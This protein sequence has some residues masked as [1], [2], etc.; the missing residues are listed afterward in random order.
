MMNH[1]PIVIESFAC[2]DS[3]SHQGEPVLER[4]EGKNLRNL[5]NGPIV[6][7][8]EAKNLRNLGKGMKHCFVR[9]H[10]HG[11][12]SQRAVDQSSWFYWVN[13]L[14]QG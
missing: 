6:I 4:S 8:S 3:E 11:C 2:C 13:Q 1:L 14:E 5:G 12:L 9:L 10:Q 7:L